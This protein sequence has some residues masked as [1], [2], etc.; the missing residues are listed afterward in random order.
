[1]KLT[2]LN[3]PFGFE[4]DNLFCI[5]KRDNNPKRNFLF[6]SKLLGKHIPVHP[7]VCKA[8]GQLLASLY[9][10]Q[11]NAAPLVEY[12][13]HPSNNNEEIQ[14]LLNQSVYTDKRT[15]IIGFAETATGLGMSV[16]SC[17]RNCVYYSTTRE[18]F[19]NK[20]FLFSFE[21]EHSHATTHKCYDQ[22]NT[23]FSSFDE[24]ILVDDEITTGNS[25][26]HLIK[27][28]CRLSGVK[29]YRILTILD[30]RNDFNK[31]S[32]K[33]MQLNEEIDIKVFSVLS[34]D[35]TVDDHTVFKEGNPPILSKSISSTNLEAGFL[36][37]KCSNGI[38][39]DDY[40]YKNSGRLGVYQSEIQEI[41][42]FAKKAAEEIA[43]KFFKEQSNI[44]VLVLSEGEDIYIPSRIASC[45]T[46]TADVFFKTTTRSPI[47]CDGEIIKEKHQYIGRNEVTYYFYNKSEIEEEYDL[48]LFLGEFSADIQLTK[49][50]V[51]IVFDACNLENIMTKSA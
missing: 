16:A 2:N 7:D 3:N 5:G 15:L 17:I 42:S 45:L 1:M 4:L 38:K 29:K 27:Q 13:K 37:T 18:T 41:E 12:L 19:T 30:W 10:P 14:S 43:E 46:S 32:F 40:F 47:Y 31:E 11:I 26:L 36:R 51:S 39:W 50:M 23:S 34:G 20:E 33:N 22:L 6:I 28:L 24:I 35:I 44:R 49:N 8:T 25:M 21:E 48:V 9:Y